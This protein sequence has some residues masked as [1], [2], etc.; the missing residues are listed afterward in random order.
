[1]H[2]H[3]K[4]NK[5]LIRPVGFSSSAALASEVGAVTVQAA[6]LAGSGPGSSNSSS[7][8][9]SG[10]ISHD[11]SKYLTFD[12]YVELQQQYKQQK[13]ALQQQGA[14]QPPPAEVAAAQQS[15]EGSEDGSGKR[16]P[17]NKGR[18]HS[19]RTWGDCVRVT[20]SCM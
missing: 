6:A 2:Q 3:Q 15:P 18:K 20:G 13:A 9:S 16:V 19:A 12:E 8:S 1:V 4:A 5:L 11:Q 17:W 10:L 7:G 14:Q